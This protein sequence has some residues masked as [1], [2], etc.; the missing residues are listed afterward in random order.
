M[1]ILYV[2]KGSIEV[3]ANGGDNDL[4]GTDFDAC[5]A[6]QLARQVAAAGAE[7]DAEGCAAL[8][9]PPCEKHV[10]AS[11]AEELKVAV[12]ASDEA[13]R[14]C[15][16]RIKGSCDKLDLVLSRATFEKTCAALFDRAVATVKTTLEDGMLTTKDVD[17]VVLV[18]GTS[19]VPRVRALLKEHLGVASLNTEIDPDVTVAVGA[20]S[21]LD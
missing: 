6:D 1:S 7:P 11:L 20:A 15:A 9:Y 2:Q 19:R 21:I 3:V 10:L 16:A 13:T 18:G 14:T 12:S 4:G 17:E 5:V 8:D